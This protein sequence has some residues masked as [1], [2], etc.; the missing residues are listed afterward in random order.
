MS[1]SIPSPLAVIPHGNHHGHDPA[2]QTSARACVRIRE[3]VVR[4]SSTHHLIE[5]RR[6]FPRMPMQ[7]TIFDVRSQ[8]VLHIEMNPASA[9]H[10]VR[11]KYQS[12]VHVQPPHTT[13]MMNPIIPNTNFPPNHT[14][15]MN[16]A[17]STMTS[18]T[19]SS[20]ASPVPDYR[21]TSFCPVQTSRSIP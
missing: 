6:H 12:R 17:N 9:I 20:V 3:H 11:A 2:M 5:Q 1:R 13:S 19:L 10:R 15:N 4:A 16:A 8:T 14:T 18:R 21:G 7:G